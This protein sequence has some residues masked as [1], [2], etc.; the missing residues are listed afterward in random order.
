LVEDNENERQ[1]L[2]TILKMANLNVVS[3]AD[4]EEA[5]KFLDDNP[6]PDLVLIDMQM[7]RLNGPQTISII[8]NSKKHSDL[9]IYG[10]SGSSR[11]EL[12]VPL[13]NRGVNRWFSKPVQANE[14]LDSILNECET[15]D[16]FGVGF[17]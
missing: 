10:V 15:N 2:A 4:G 1:L 8:R 17:N 14:L 16:A 6:S 3:V 9:P 11:S 12:N 13:S 5:L 7:P